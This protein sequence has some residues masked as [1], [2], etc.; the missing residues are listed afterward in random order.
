MA[1][2]CLSLPKPIDIEGADRFGGEVYYTHHWP[3]EGV[4]FT[5][6]ARGDRHR[7]VGGSSRSR[8][9]QGRPELTVFQ[10]SP[11]SQLP[12]T[13]VHFRRIV[14]PH[15]RPT[16]P[17]TRTPAKHSHRG[18]PAEPLELARG[19]VS[20]E[21]RTLGFEAAYEAGELFAIL[22][23]FADQQSIPEANDI[24][25]EMMRE[26]SSI[27]NNPDG[28]VRCPRRTT[29]RRPSGRAST[30]ATSR[31]N[32]PTSVSST[33]A[34]TR[35]RASP[36]PASTRPATRFEFDAIV[37]ATGFD[38]MTGALV[39]VDITGRDGAALK[40]KWADGPTTYL[41]LT[42]GFR[43]S[44]PSP[45]GSPSVLSNMSVWMDE[46]GGLGRRHA[47]GH[48]D[49]CDDRA[50]SAAQ[51]GWVRRVND[52]ADIT[53]HPTANSWYMGANVPGKPRVFLP[54][55]GGVDARTARSATRSYRTTTSASS[56]PAA[57]SHA[58]P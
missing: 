49:G 45:A 8:S 3:H 18:V 19:D 53:L 14:S 15:S 23:I 58:V 16:A 39:S 27:V 9:S 28:G 26:R 24:V 31:L 4:D 32:L 38:A 13:M 37:Y 1:T 2:G 41:G 22:G 56:F 25:A 52:C 50:H 12:R 5:G 10:R 7:F 51:S 35:S 46:R 21:E 42:T 33:C 54:Y 57:A 30:R 44:L 17:R 34:R 55:I 43:T 20:E 29:T 36:R 47:R 11:A 48:K 6:T 40:Q